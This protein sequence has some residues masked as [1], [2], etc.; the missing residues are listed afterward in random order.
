[1]KKDYPAKR[2]YAVDKIDSS[3]PIYIKMNV[4][5]PIS[6]NEFVT[7]AAITIEIDFVI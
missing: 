7:W 1:M 6:L 5:E 2:A 3:R 4:P